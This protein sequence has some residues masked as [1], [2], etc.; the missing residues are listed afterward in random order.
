MSLKMSWPRWLCRLL[1]LETLFILGSSITLFY[2]IWKYKSLKLGFQK[3]EESIG[4]ILV[5]P[6]SIVKKSK[7]VKKINKH[8][9][10]CRRIFEEI[11]RE[12]FIST[13]PDWLKNPVTNRNLELDGFCDHIK[14]P[15]GRGLA[16]EYDGEQHS[17]Y[18]AGS[19]FHRKGPSEF[20]YQVKKDSWKDITC[21]NRGVLL[22]RIPSF[23]PWS[24]LERY[25]KQELRKK[26]LNV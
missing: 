25:I 3:L 18:I 8:E 6:G 7:K 24:D 22:I 12:K 4:D 21:K 14:T 11:F 17:R 9:E 2:F 10:E 23:V 16:F 15:M 13:R 5:V 26:G 19:H 1:H 20:V